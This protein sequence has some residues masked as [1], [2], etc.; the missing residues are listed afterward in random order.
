MGKFLVMLL[1]VIML[2]LVLLVVWHNDLSNLQQEILLLKQNRQQ[3][4]AKIEQIVQQDVGNYLNETDEQKK[5]VGA[6][7]ILQKMLDALAV[8]LELVTSPQNEKISSEVN[9]P[10]DEPLLKAESS[11]ATER[12]EIISSQPSEVMA[13]F[14]S[15]GPGQE[16]TT[17]QKMVIEDLYLQL[18][19]SHSVMDQLKSRYSFLLGRF[20]GE[21]SFFK[22]PQIIPLEMSFELEQKKIL[23]LS[24]ELY[25]RYSPEFYL[26]GRGSRDDIFHILDGDK[27]RALWLKFDENTYFQMFYN[28]TDNSFVGNFYKKK[29]GK[30]EWQGIFHVHKI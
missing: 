10:K 19:S 24:Y 20:E 12:Q 13:S 14:Y 8:D 25:L 15:D 18:R 3:L 27:S 1:G 5:I 30:F 23:H 29:N 16:K 7:K 4:G 28:K 21:V 6:K 26:G 17:L 22:S 11:S 9:V 2:Q